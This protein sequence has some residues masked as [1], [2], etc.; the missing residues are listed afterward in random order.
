MFPSTAA[1]WQHRP[2]IRK[3]TNR[4]DGLQLWQKAM[5]DLVGPSSATNRLLG[6]LKLPTFAA[7][8]SKVGPQYWHGTAL[9]L[10]VP[11]Y[12]STALTIAALHSKVGPQHCTSTGMA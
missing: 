1:L 3:L 12:P 5:D 11:S 6:W 8:H 2:E 10:L 4:I 7:L 9:V